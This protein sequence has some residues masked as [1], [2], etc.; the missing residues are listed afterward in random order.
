MIDS[1]RAAVKRPR[2]QEKHTK[3]ARQQQCHKIQG[4]VLSLSESERGGGG[5]QELCVWKKVM[6]CV[7]L[8]VCDACLC[9][10]VCVSAGGGTPGKRTS[11]Q[12]PKKNPFHV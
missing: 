10:G 3:T 12:P 4:L 8:N 7:L 1:L 11:T 2:L 6:R 5:S 9:V